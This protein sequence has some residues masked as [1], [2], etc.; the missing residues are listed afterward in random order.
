MYFR[1]GNQVE[2]EMCFII[3]TIQ[4]NFVSRNTFMNFDEF[5]EIQ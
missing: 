2:F 4:N 5:W 1:R 3:F